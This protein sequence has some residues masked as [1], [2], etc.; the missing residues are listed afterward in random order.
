MGHRGRHRALRLA[1]AGVAVALAAPALGGCVRLLTLTPSQHPLD[2]VA[3]TV[4]VCA[5]DG[6]ACPQ[7]ALPVNA[8]T[9]IGQ[10]LLGF[11][12]PGATDPPA[13]FDST[14]PAG[15]VSFSQS[16]TFTAELERLSPAGPGRRW[17]GYV[18]NPLSYTSGSG[19]QRFTASARFTLRQGPDGTP[20]GRPFRYRVVAGSRVS[21]GSFPPSRPVTCG[22]GSLDEASADSSTICANSPPVSALGSDLTF[23]TR[24]AGVLA[25]QAKAVAAPGSL[26]AIPFIVAYSGAG[27]DE[28]PRLSLS[29]S[30]TLP[31]ATPTPTPNVLVPAADGSSSALVTVNVPTGAK[32]GAYE[33]RL[34]ATAPSVFRFLPIVVSLQQDTGNPRSRTGVGTL[35]VPTPSELARAGDVTIRDARAVVRFRRSRSRGFIQVR[36]TASGGARRLNVLVQR[37]GLVRSL[38][39]TPTV[40][41]SAFRSLPVRPGAFRKRIRIPAGFLPGRYTVSLAPVTADQV[42]LP[43]RRATVLVPAPREGVVDS[44]FVSASRRGP[45]VRRFT[46]RPRTLFAN[47]RLAPGALPAKGRANRLTIRWFRNGKTIG[48]LEPR[49]RKRS[50]SAFVRLRN[51]APVPRGR[52]RAVLRSGRTVVAVTTVRVG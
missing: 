11:R 12:V 51:R 22:A 9:G 52:Y 23:A 3:L 35:T 42:A 43:Q 37:R 29:A 26:A 38:G 34:T 45:S 14:D 30:T 2:Q 36:G 21:Q 19:P 47:F 8:S 20:F 33:V 17:V 48:R 28:A 1:T 32:P 46:T 4:E 50:L 25:D 5:V 16:A 40:R 31:G 10:A 13:G 41:A 24:D 27:G 18:S 49:P 15:V 39:R 6:A 7:G 44:A